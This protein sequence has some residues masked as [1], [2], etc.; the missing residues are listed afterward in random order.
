M[1]G[2]GCN[3]S[4]QRL[5]PSSSSCWLVHST[6]QQWP[7][8]PGWH[9][10]LSGTFCEP[11]IEPSIDRAHFGSDPVCESPRS[12]HR[13]WRRAA[14]SRGPHKQQE[15][16]QAIIP[17]SRAPQPTLRPGGM[18]GGARAYAAAAKDRG[19]NDAGTRLVCGGVIHARVDRV[20]LVAVG[21]GGGRGETTRGMLVLC[22][23]QQ[24]PS[25]P[26]L[27]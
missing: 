26:L 17:S 13:F 16:H 9:G 22:W 3:G 20:R 19:R 11:S 1:I 4:E 2:P 25:A 24:S 23:T 10:L 8:A 6:K 5:D 27:G 21:D 15:S 14:S 12:T 7:G 18:A